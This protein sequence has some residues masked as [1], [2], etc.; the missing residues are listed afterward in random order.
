MYTYVQRVQ[1]HYGSNTNGQ[2]MKE[3]NANSSKREIPQIPFIPPPPPAAAIAAA[4]CSRRR[5][6]KLRKLRP[7]SPRRRTKRPPNDSCG[8]SG[9][10][11]AAA[12]P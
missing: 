7:A 3:T 2:G 1:L 11:T 9:S 10:V 12:L 8:V 5:S 6:R 4:H